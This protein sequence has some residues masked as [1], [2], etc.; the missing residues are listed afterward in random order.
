MR[1]GGNEMPDD[2]QITLAF[3]ITRGYNSPSYPVKTA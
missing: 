1:N 2:K 3:N